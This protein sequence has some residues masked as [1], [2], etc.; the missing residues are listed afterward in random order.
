VWTDTV[1][2]QAPQTL[3]RLQHGGRLLDIGAGA[4]YALVHYA[5]RFPA[6]EVV[7]LELNGPSVELA[8][9]AVAEAGWPTGS[10]CA[11]VT[12][13]SWTRRTPTTWSR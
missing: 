7:G 4:G 6:A 13:T 10:S 9:R 11:T 12:P 2:P 5:Q 3:A 1:L 8:R